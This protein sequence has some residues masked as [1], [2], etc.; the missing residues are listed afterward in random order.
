MG[1]GFKHG[2]GGGAGSSLNFKIVCG[3][4]QPASA[5]ENAIWINTD[6][7]ITGWV[8][9][10]SEP[11]SP[12]EGLV[13][14]SIGVASAAAFNAVKKQELM[15]YP[16]AAKQY[17]GGSWANKGAM[18]YL[19]GAWVSFSTEAVYLCLSSAESC[20][21]CRMKGLPSFRDTYHEYYRCLQRA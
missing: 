13:W 21:V 19:N 3:T 5:S 15:L 2:A 20:R 6:T 16:I 12:V 10:V 17:V 8:F 7:N 18:I 11:E 4:S 9:S 14:I 1:K